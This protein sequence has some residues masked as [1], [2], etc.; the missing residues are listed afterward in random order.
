M[1]RKDN[2]K[3]EI[4]R[5]LCK[6]CGICAFVC[7]KNV[8]SFNRLKGPEVINL[9]NCIKCDMCVMMCPDMAITISEDIIKEGARK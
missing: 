1:I 9:E 4:N 2:I 7:P 3:I 5:K 6:N 8:Y